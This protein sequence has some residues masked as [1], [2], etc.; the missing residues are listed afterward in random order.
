MWPPTPT[1]RT[2]YTRTTY[3]LPAS[4][5]RVTVDRELRWESASGFVRAVGLLILESRTAPGSTADLDRALWS[6]GHR[7]VRLSK[8]GTGLSILNPDLPGNKWHRLAE[9]LRAAV[10]NY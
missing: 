4:G 10:N 1:M 5:C 9:P 6:L 8:Y 2:S 3:L 7:P